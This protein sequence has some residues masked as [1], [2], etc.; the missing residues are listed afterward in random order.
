M[1]IPPPLPLHNI[2]PPLPNANKIA[3]YVFYVGLSLITAMF[4]LGMQ[5]RDYQA[6]EKLAYLIVGALVGALKLQTNSNN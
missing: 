5:N 1:E 2:P 3:G 6:F 4:C